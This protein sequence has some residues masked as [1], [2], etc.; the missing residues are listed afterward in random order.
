LFSKKVS[1]NLFYFGF[2]FVGLSCLHG[3]HALLI[4]GATSIERV[5]FVIQAIGQSF[6]ETLAA[7]ILIQILPRAFLPWIITLTA[8]LFVARIVDFPLVRL[9]GLSFWDATTL[10]SKE[11]IYNF[12]EQ[13]YSSNVSIGMWVTGALIGFAIVELAVVAFYLTEKYAKKCELSL[14]SL[15]WTFGSV[16]LLFVV[17]EC[18]GLFFVRGIAYE[19]YAQ[20]LPWKRGILQRDGALVTLPFT[21]KEREFTTEVA[22]EPLKTKPDIYLFV[23]ESLRDDFITRDVAPNLTSFRKKNIRLDLT[24]SNANATQPSWFSIFHSRFPM[25]WGSKIPKGALPMKILKEMGYK[26]HVY[27]SARLSFFRMDEVIFGEDT[28]LADSI[29]TFFGTENEPLYA[30]DGRVIDKLCEDM[31]KEVGGR[32]FIV[33]LDSTHFEY[34]WPPSETTFLPIE[35]PVN[36]VKLAFF[37]GNLG[38]LKNRYRNALSYVDS[39]FGKVMDHLQDKK[40][41]IVVFTGDHGEEFYENGHLFHASALTIEQT[42][43]PIY[44]KM[45]KKPLAKMSSHIDIFPSIIH[46]LVGD[47]RYG[48]YF[49]GQS[50]FSKNR[51]P[52]LVSARYN[53]GR[54]PYEFMLHNGKC[55]LLARFSNEGEIFKSDAVRILTLEHVE[56]KQIAQ[57]F[58]EAF[59][60]LFS[61][62]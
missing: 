61:T 45:G 33:F 53:L 35:D 59:D 8:V 40:G 17:I 14:P 24:L 11:H 28:Y 60:Y 49:D 34:S 13:L 43:V 55:K 41:S 39:L 36:Y 51:W 27:T 15:I 50:I 47:D 22:V 46:Y 2:L 23:V 9:L 52:F 1:V 48:E 4:D 54:T 10:I 20:A 6:L 18:A 44:Y 19:N 57:E 32:V 26:I 37:K 3:Y 30:R 62:R 12:V 56:E 7:L 38:P 25:Y 16:C 29:F 5:Y 31:Q 58:G 42:G 21:L